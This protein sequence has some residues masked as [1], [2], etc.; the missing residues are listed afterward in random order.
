[1]R[2]DGT[3]N[4]PLNSWARAYD[5]SPDARRAAMWAIVGCVLLAFHGALHLGQNVPLGIAA[6]L[7]GS[8]AVIRLSRFVIRINNR[9]ETPSNRPPSVLEEIDERVK[10]LNTLQSSHRVESLCVR[11]LTGFG[12]IGLVALAFKMPWLEGAL[13]ALLAVPLAFGVRS[14]IRD[15]ESRLEAKRRQLE[16]TPAS[17]ERPPS[18]GCDLPH[19]RS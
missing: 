4:E 12:V 9:S 11:L 17:G 19:R 8:V 2:T 1:M 13:T 14:W 10:R 6:I 7:A 18:G 16:A 3:S 5:L 15:E